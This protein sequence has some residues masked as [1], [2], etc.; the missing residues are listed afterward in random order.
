M[1]APAW[2][3]VSYIFQAECSQ[4]WAAFHFHFRI[5]FYTQYICF[6]YILYSDVRCSYGLL[7]FFCMFLFT[8]K[9]HHLYVVIALCSLMRYYLVSSLFLNSRMKRK[10]STKLV[11]EL[12]SLD[13]DAGIE[14]NGWN[15]K[16]IYNMKKNISTD[17][18]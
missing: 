8:F 2:E 16:G 12:C 11:S 15:E 9:E 1:Y 3:P 18:P 14:W 5:S 6:L 17:E 10:R 4:H 13:K 7:D